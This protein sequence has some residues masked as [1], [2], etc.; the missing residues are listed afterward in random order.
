[1]FSTCIDFAP[2]V[3]P[4]LPLARYLT[5]HGNPRSNILASLRIMRGRSKESVWRFGKACSVFFVKPLQAHAKKLRRSPDFIQG[6]KAV[7][8]EPF[9]EGWLQGSRAWGRPSDVLVMPDG[10]LLVADDQAGTIYRI[11]Y[12]K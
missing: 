2:F 1:M 7:K 12:R 5:E 3:N 9:A 10:S 6:N 11:A 4:I 8:Y